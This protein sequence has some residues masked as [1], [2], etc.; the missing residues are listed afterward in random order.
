MYIMIYKAKVYYS[1]ANQLFY[2][3]TICNFDKFIGIIPWL[4]TK[5]ISSS[6]S[7]WNNTSETEA[8]SLIYDKKIV[9][10]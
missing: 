7:I 6:N 8:M 10:T 3:P 5:S 2:K 4:K 9:E 1:L